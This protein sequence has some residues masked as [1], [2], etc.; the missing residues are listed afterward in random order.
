MSDL[1]SE[2]DRLNALKEYDILDSLPEAD[3]EA[4]TELAS[5]I[6]GT[7]ISLISLIDDSRQWFKSNHGLSVK[8][9]PREYAFCTH[10]IQSPSE[11]FVVSDSRNDNRFS[12]NPL[13]TGDPH[14]I[15]YAGAPLIDSNGFALGS[16]CVID[17]TP[18]TLSNTQLSAL[19]TL[20][21]SVV[22]LIEMRKMQKGFK[23]MNKALEDR[24]EETSETLK[25]I[26]DKIIHGV[27][28]LVQDVKVM[29]DEMNNH[30]NSLLGEKIDNAMKL[31][32]IVRKSFQV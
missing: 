25:F 16:L 24:H 10:T 22:N 9:T 5:Q 32:D 18:K 4:I 23:K 14:V 19:K 17:H 30:Q 31:L 3:Y 13:V 12:Q 8:E 2:E 6:C 26:S 27:Y 15:F 11:V 21:T 29:I 20:A 1:S 28:P 7:P